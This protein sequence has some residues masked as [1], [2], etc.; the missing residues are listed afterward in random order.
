MSYRAPGSTYRLQFHSGFRFV[1]G[2]V[3]RDLRKKE[4][5]YVFQSYWAQEPMVHIYGHTW[6]VRWGGE[7]LRG[8]DQA[9]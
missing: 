3:E 8:L 1:D 5:H 2:V 7:G 9:T 4:S 6:A